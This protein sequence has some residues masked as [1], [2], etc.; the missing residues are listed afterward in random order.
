[1]PQIQAVCGA[2]VMSNC[3][4]CIEALRSRLSQIFLVLLLA[5]SG[6]AHADTY[7]K[8]RQT[9]SVTLGVREASVPFSF[10]HN[11]RP[12]GYSVELCLAAV[13]EIKSELRMPDLRVHF[14]TVS[15][16]Q[17]IPH[18][19]SGEIDLECGSTTHT[20]A[21]AEQ[22]DFSYTVFVAG[23]RLLSSGK[24]P[25]SDLNDLRGA[26]V[27]LSKGTTSE[28]LFKQLSENQVQ[29]QLL[30][31]NSNAE[32]FEALKAGRISAFPQDDSLL[33]GLIAGDGAAG[34][35][36]LSKFALSVEPYAIMMRK[37]DSSLRGA[38]DRALKRLYASGEIQTIYARWFET[39]Q[40]KI[41][42]SRMTRDSFMRP[43]RD[44]G[45]AVGLGY[46]L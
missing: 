1:M 17:R 32:A 25:I 6:A 2:Q 9:G 7:L 26:K 3:F 20:K 42:L 38:V 13:E 45:V 40:L 10:V 15:A 14:K 29:M 44:A 4:G 21:R 39:P 41:T 5:S 11:G 22:V 46:S 35:W 18:L 27:G 16:P 31:F 34:Q 37:G 8:I 28:K 30:T 43:S 36:T 24:F 19:L 33:Q 23:M 12:T